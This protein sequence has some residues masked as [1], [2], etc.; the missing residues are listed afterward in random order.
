[1][2]DPLTVVE[3]ALQQ[4]GWKYERSD[5]VTV[6]TNFTF[7]AGW[8]VTIGIRNEH[9]ARTILF[10][11]QPAFRTNAN[12]ELLLVHQDH[13]YTDAQVAEVTAAL[14]HANYELVLGS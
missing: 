4:R 13:D 6:Y 1:M 12:W 10:V 11:F 5:I 8:A 7:E 3:S 9:Q 2:L 14:L